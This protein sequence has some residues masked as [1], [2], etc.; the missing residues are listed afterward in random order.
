MAL[1]PWLQFAVP[2]AT[3]FFKTTL[4]ITTTKMAEAN[5]RI[6]I[7]RSPVN[8]LYYHHGRVNTAAYL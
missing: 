1:T 3:K 7:S 2:V 8:F 6:L 4:I 5:P